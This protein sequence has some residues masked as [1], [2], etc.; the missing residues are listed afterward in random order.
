MSTKV[1]PEKKVAAAAP[2]RRVNYGAWTFALL[3]MLAVLIFASVKAQHGAW[4]GGEADMFLV[5][6]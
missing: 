5:D 2:A 6:H 4:L 1:L 3:V